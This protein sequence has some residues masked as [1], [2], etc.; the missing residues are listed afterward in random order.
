[1][2][3]FATAR[4]LLLLSAVVLLFGC[5]SQPSSDE[6][7]VGAS[8]PVRADSPTGADLRPVIVAL[9]DSLTAGAGVDPTENYPSRLQSMLDQLGYRY[10]VVNAGVSG[11]TSAQGL[12]RLETVRQQRPRIVVLALG[13]NDGLRGLP[14]DATG[15]NLGRIIRSLQS[16]GAQVVLTGMIMP[17]NYGPQY[18]RSFRELFPDLARQLNVPLVGF[19]LEGVAGI[20]SLNQADGIH[21]TGEGY[22]KVVENIWPVLE[23]LLE[24]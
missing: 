4:D 10:R 24:K 2:R 17:P 23:P 8:V 22:A 12:N 19:L 3:R 15:S 7:E 6:P 9:G 14:V 20:P 5:R 16:D 1:M 13:A 21:P 11:N 18:T